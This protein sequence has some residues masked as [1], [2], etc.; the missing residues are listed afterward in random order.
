LYSYCARRRENGWI[1]IQEAVTIQ[2]QDRTNA[3]IAS[4]AESIGH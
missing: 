2:S 4:L 3:Q 1:E